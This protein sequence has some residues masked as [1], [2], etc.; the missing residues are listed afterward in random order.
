M[1]K[2]ML[3]WSEKEQSLYSDSQQKLNPWAWSWGQADSTPSD[4]QT[5]EPLDALA[6]LASQLRQLPIAVIGPR[7]AS[8]QEYQI[9]E[10]LGAALANVGLQ[11]MCGGKNGVMEASAKGHLEA[12]GRPIGLIPEDDWT[13]ANPYISIPIA[14]GIG[15]AR[16]VLLA[17][18]CPVLIAV[19]GGY[20]TMSEMA[21]GLHF[22]KL[23]LALGEAPQLPGVVYCESVPE[24]MHK[25]ANYLLNPD[26]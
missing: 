6:Q 19:G 22:E 4:L 3:F 26:K 21:F 20:G 16:N 7:E 13:E 23:I 15:K 2:K 24:A 12:G 14:S 17:Q 5:I 1:D 8:E 11:L 9:A 18:A 10:N 25:L